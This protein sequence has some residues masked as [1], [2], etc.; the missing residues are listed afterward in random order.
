MPEGAF[1]SETLPVGSFRAANA[2]GLHDMHG[3]VWEWCRDVWHENYNGAP[4]D[5]SAWLNGGDQQERVLRGGSWINAAK[6]CR[7]AVRNGDLATDK[8]P[9]AGF[10]VVLTTKRMLR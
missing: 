8:Y 5:A 1:R 9:N 3:N 10:R 4:A 2:F 6:D 7:S